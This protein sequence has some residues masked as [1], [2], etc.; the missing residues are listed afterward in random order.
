M[1]VRLCTHDRWT[2]SCC[3]CDHVTNVGFALVVGATNNFYVNVDKTTTVVF[4]YSG[5]CFMFRGTLPALLEPG[6]SSA[7]QYMISSTI[8]FG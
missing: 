2:Y 6:T 5:A 3:D 7:Q 1:I 8:L 4:V